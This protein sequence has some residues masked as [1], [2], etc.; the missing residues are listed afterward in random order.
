[1]PKLRH[2]VWILVWPDGKVR[3][4]HAN[5]PYSYGTKAQAKV[6]IYNSTYES[7]RVVRFEAKKRKSNA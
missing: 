4:D 3:M 5:N 2:H 1:M 6:A 7:L